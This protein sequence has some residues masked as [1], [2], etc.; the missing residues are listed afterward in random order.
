MMTAEP[1]PHR[2]R[3]RGTALFLA[4]A[5]AGLGMAAFPLAGTAQAADPQCDQTAV[6]G[7]LDLSPAPMNPDLHMGFQDDAPTNGSGLYARKGSAAGNWSFR[8][9]DDG[10]FQMVNNGTGKCVE[11]VQPDSSISLHFPQLADCSGADVQ[12]FYAQKEDDQGNYRIRSVTTDK[13]L[14]ARRAYSPENRPEPVLELYGCIAESSGQ[15]WNVAG[16][17]PG[18]DK[19]SSALDAMATRYALRQFDN[20]SGVI[21]SATYD[22]TDSS[23][24]V[25]W[26]N[27]LVSQS[28][29][30]KGQGP[31]CSNP[32][33]A[34]SGDLTCTMN[35]TQTTSKETNWS[36]TFNVGITAGFSGTQK[37][38]VTAQ[39]SIGYSHTWGGSVT[40]AEMSGN[41]VL[42]VVPPGYKGWLAR[43]VPYKATT[44]DWTITTDIGKSWKGT[45]TVNQAVSGVEGYYPELVKCTDQ[46]T[47]EACTSTSNGQ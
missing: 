3:Q 13:C 6:L 2:S 36:N 24:K 10:S 23:Q 15:I 4:T 14:D 34:G 22:I 7:C 17:T 35:W 16:M 21:K 43:K 33:P 47:D 46:T 9:N 19:P 41:G 11:T 37:T 29:S 31:Y 39:L 5:L 25:T 44:G 42:V 12:K 1:I 18:Q 40:E 20:G 28:S 27:E 8:G 32:G 30:E 45:G 26:K 38:P